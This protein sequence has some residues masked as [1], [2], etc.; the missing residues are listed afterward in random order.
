[1]NRRAFISVAFLSGLTADKLFASSF[2]KTSTPQRF[3]IFLK[4]INVKIEK[5][6]LLSDNLLASAYEKNAQNWIKT[7]YTAFSSDYFLS[8]NNQLALF[9]I[10]LY[11]ASIGQI[12]LA[13][14][15]F[16]KRTDGNWLALSPI[17]AFHIEA[18]ALAST[19]LT[20]ENFEN[21]IL[22]SSKSTSI[23][24]S[25]C[26][27]N[28]HVTCKVS[29]KESITIIDAAIFEGQQAIWQKQFYSE[30]N[31]RVKSITQLV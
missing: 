23:P 27:A 18:L 6:I 14:L 8:K 16:E 5:K 31:L 2:F 11:N 9:P 7:G 17:T 21:F 24:F 25:F 22:P 13:L 26:T 29:M 10:E 12:D 28:G 20:L 4:S 30:H 19:E 3:D 1:M 15:C